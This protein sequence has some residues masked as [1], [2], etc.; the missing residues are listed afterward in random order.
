MDS[1]PTSIARSK[2]GAT[3]YV[4]NLRAGTVTVYDLGR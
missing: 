2:D 3:G 4:T 1:A